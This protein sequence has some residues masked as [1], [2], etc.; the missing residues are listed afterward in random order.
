MSESDRQEGAD[1]EVLEDI[2]FEDGDGPG[3]ESD[4]ELMEA[5]QLDD[6]DA[7]EISG[8]GEGAGDPDESEKPAEGHEAEAVM[9]EDEDEDKPRLV[10]SAVPPVVEGAVS[11]DEAEE[12][13]DDGVVDSEEDES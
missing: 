5:P 12:A 10:T 2:E 1:P 7:V 6:E 11:A 3:G 13:G 4:V 8:P 9:I